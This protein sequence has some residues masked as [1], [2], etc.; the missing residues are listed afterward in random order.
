MEKN[1]WLVQ[2]VSDPNKTYEI[3]KVGDRFVCSCPDAMYR[4][5]ECKHCRMIKKRLEEEKEKEKNE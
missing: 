5:R 4:D 3:M 2:S 1:R